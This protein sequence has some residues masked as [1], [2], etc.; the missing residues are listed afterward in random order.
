M[1]VGPFVHLSYNL[2][3]VSI[4][5][6]GVLCKAQICSVQ[7]ENVAAFLPFSAVRRLDTVPSSEM[8]HEENVSL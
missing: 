3:S 2:K 5:L 4:S 8:L 7:W 6:E 1:Y